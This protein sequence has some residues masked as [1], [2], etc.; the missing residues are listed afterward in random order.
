MIISALEL[1]LI[2]K[3]AS[4]SAGIHSRDG[5]IGSTDQ[6]LM[7]NDLEVRHCRVLVAVSDH[8]GVGA[9]ARALGL[10]QSTVSET[11]LSLERLIGAPLTLRQPGHE[12]VLTAVALALLPHARAIV[13]ASEA[14]LASVISDHRGVIR[15]GAVES[16]ST[17]ILP[18]ALTEFRSRWPAWHVQIS[19]GLCDDLRKRVQRRELDAAIT[20]ESPVDASAEE[21]SVRRALAPARLCLFVSSQEA[22][23][24]LSIRRLDLARRTLLVPDADG[25]FTTLMRA[26]FASSQEQP[27]FE[28]A[29]SIEGVKIGVRGGKCVGLLPVYAVA[30]ELA[31]GEFHDVLV[32]EPLPTVVLGLTTHSRSVEGSALHDM[33]RCIDHSAAAIH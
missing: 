21:G 3:Y 17:Y 7:T 28:S 26:W 5:G 6:S 11:L 14:A 10:A 8:S 20:V 1:D 22:R 9:A 31:L 23:G 30:K 24:G 2:S 15:L 32:D 25:A 27:R 18:T 12:A 33:I 13:A 16:A 19:I 4:Y 29:G